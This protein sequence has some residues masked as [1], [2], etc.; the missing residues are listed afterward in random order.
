MAEE[1]PAKPHCRRPADGQNDAQGDAEA[2]G[3]P[4]CDERCDHAGNNGAVQRVA[5]RKEMACSYGGTASLSGGRARPTIAFADVGK[6]QRS[7]TAMIINVSG[8]ME[9]HRHHQ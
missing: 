6:G 4:D 1:D 2:A 5:G 3:E 9:R 7:G 8:V